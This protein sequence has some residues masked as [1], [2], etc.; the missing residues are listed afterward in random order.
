MIQLKEA[1]RLMEQLDEHGKPCRFD[2]VVWE[3]SEKRGTG[4]E[5]ITYKNVSLNDVKPSAE[6]K[7]KAEFR[8]RKPIYDEGKPKNPHHFENQTRNIR[9]A[10]YQVRKIHI[11][12][13]KSFN[14][15]QIIY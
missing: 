8:R 13:I 9:L 1:L 10:N 3:F 12:F 7:V 15:F 14:Q 2:L 5:E 11:R 6:S 4:G